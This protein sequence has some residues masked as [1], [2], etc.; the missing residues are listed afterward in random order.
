M[1]L[2]SGVPHPFQ[3]CGSQR[4]ASSS[5]LL[6]SRP[7]SLLRKERARCPESK[8]AI[9]ESKRALTLCPM[10]PVRPGGTLTT[11]SS[12]PSRPDSPKLGMKRL[13]NTCLAHCG[14]AS[15]NWM[16]GPDAATRPRPPPRIDPDDSR[17]IRPPGYPLACP[18]KRPAALARRKPPGHPPFSQWTERRSAGAPFVVFTP[19]PK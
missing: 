16:V 12:S 11:D 7:S 18:R 2:E 8:S 14:W 4:G 15:T 19:S 3:P 10:H 5:P 13:A 9:D 6:A 17:S 1:V